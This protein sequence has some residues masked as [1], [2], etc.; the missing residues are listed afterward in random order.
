[1]QK[2]LLISLSLDNALYDQT[3]FVLPLEGKGFALVSRLYCWIFSYRATFIVMQ[4]NCWDQLYEMTVSPCDV[5]SSCMSSI[6]LTSG[7]TL[8][9]CGVEQNQKDEKVMWDH[10]ASWIFR[11]NGCGGS[12]KLINVSAV[13]HIG[14]C[15]AWRC[16]GKPI[17]I[18]NLQTRAFLSWALL[19]LVGSWAQK[20]A[21]YVFQINHLN[22]LM[23]QKGHRFTLILL[24]KTMSMKGHQRV[25]IC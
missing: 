23:Q 8:E 4:I 16:R 10:P 24:L 6:Y 22:S 5:C 14:P 18:W 17:I 25:S 15:L 7:A 21:F 12:G 11:V 1:M 13:V 9:S 19:V 3:Y 2:P 20:W